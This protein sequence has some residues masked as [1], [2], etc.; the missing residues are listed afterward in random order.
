MK[1][2]TYLLSLYL[3]FLSCSNT[4]QTTVEK[5]R[6]KACNGDVVG[7]F[8][9]VDKSKVEENIREELTAAQQPSNSFEKFGEL[10]GQALVGSMIPTVLADIWKAYEEEIT[11]GKAGNICKMRILNSKG[12]LAPDEVFL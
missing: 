2:S 6:E 12:K 9:Y 11:K 4:P 3:L 5:M 10:L 7:F 8:K 1:K